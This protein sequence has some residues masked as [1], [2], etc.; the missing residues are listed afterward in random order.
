[1]IESP[2]VLLSNLFLELT[3]EPSRDAGAGKEFAQLLELQLDRVSVAESESEPGSPLGEE[4]PDASAEVTWWPFADGGRPAPATVGP[5]SGPAGDILPQ[6]GNPLPRDGGQGSPRTVWEPSQAGVQLS[7]D[8][9]SQ[10]LADIQPSQFDPEAPAQLG[11]DGPLPVQ[12]DLGTSDKKIF[13]SPPR[14]R[15]QPPLEVAL[16]APEMES[17]PAT[18]G[19]ARPTPV[20]PLAETTASHAS[21]DTGKPS[22]S[23]RAFGFPTSPAGVFSAASPSLEPWTARLSAIGLPK[24]LPPGWVQPVPTLPEHAAVVPTLPEHAAVVPTLPEHAAV[25]PALPES[26]VVSP[27]VEDEPAMV[28]GPRQA[29]DL[30]QEPEGQLFLDE[31]LVAAEPARTGEPVDADRQALAAS[32]TSD[33]QEPAF[34]RSQPFTPAP[35]RMSSGVSGSGSD[36]FVS[37]LSLTL[38]TPMGHARW[39]EAFS[40][41]IVRM[42]RQDMQQA[43]IQLDPVELGPIDIQLSMSGGELSVAFQAQHA[44]TR[45]ALEQSLP[46]L[47][48]MLGEAG[49]QLGNV[50]VNGQSDRGQQRAFTP[51]PAESSA[52]RPQRDRAMPEEM[53]GSPRTRPPVEPGRIDYFA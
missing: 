28:G 34:A 36:T 1:M 43:Q 51:V 42:A 25:V 44:A 32:S 47:R 49:M 2:Q 45:E 12:A 18:G 15:P 9:L 41:Q 14:P 22:P 3:G 38:S 31:Q 5:Y 26:A 19:V 23:G 20:S 53:P 37:G 33:R 50:D 21:D 11:G 17:E 40:S 39:N 4:E 6:A 35:E 46:R 29:M 16:T 30:S 10:W 8:R 24:D 7:Q 27:A 48:E 13:E 52:Y